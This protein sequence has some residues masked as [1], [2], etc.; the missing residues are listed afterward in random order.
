MEFEK[1]DQK[2]NESLQEYASEVKR[3]AHL[4]IGDSSGECLERVKI[5]RFISGIKDVYTKRETYANPKLTFAET[6]AYAQTRE[7]A[8][9]I[10]RASYKVNKVEFETP[11]V[12]T[13]ILSTLKSL[14]GMNRSGFKTQA[15]KCFK[16]GKPG[17]FARKCKTSSSRQEVQLKNPEGQLARWIERLQSYDF[18]IEHCKGNTHGN[19]D[20]MSRRP[21]N[22]ECKH[23][24]KAEGKED[25][26][27][28]RLM[29]I[30][31]AEKW[32][33]SNLRK[34]QQEDPDLELLMHGLEVNIRPSKAAESPIAK[35]YWAQWNSLELISC[36]ECGK[37]KMAS[38]LGS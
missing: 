17:H 18:T 5:Q 13:K 19:A 14:E 29:K 37:M 27:D 23:C 32:E 31:Q 20:A 33:A 3:L 38:A 22:I 28:V 4:A 15:R 24:S 26:I 35:A 21:R 10:S 36:I 1:R 25:I 6:L 2:S 16:C 30:T 34:C 9:L 7:T 12:M 8:A 11:D